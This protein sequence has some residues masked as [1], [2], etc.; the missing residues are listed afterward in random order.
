[1]LVSSD[2]LG[3]TSFHSSHGTDVLFLPFKL[4]NSGTSLVPLMPLLFSGL[5]QSPF[6]D[7][8]SLLKKRMRCSKKLG[9]LRL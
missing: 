2:I 1:M 9:W 8:K 4:N 5:S 3:I 6:E 7:R